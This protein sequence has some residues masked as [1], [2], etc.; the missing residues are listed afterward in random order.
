MARL[1]RR[2]AVPITYTKYIVFFMC[3]YISAL[4]FLIVHGIVHRVVHKRFLKVGFRARY[5]TL[6]NSYWGQPEKHLVP[7]P[8]PWQDPSVTESTAGVLL[9]FYML[10]CF[11]ASSAGTRRY[12]AV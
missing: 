3:S 2:T 10:T 7:P 1:D 9:V 6:R 11:L 12:L 5:R 4:R 8:K